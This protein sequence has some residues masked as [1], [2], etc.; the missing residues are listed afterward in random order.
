[1]LRHWAEE[2]FYCTHEMGL[3]QT[4]PVL[5][6]L[7]N[8]QSTN[9]F[10]HYPADAYYFGNQNWRAY[11]H[12]H[13]SPLNLDQEHGHLHIFT[14]NNIDEEWAHCFA[15]SMDKFGQPQYI[16]TTNLWVTEGAWLEVDQLIKSLHQLED[17]N[18]EDLLILDWLTSFI[19]TFQ[20]EI[21]DA[22]VKRDDT[23]SIYSRDDINEC[24]EDRNLYH[25]SIIPVSLQRKLNT[26]LV[27]KQVTA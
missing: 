5:L 11:Y 13:R 2:L 10:Q 4:N 17:D 20:D 15:L 26:L 3:Q 22:I 25:L 16:F 7:G 27:K 12:S 21:K 19:L 18:G 24:F 6:I 8:T 14:R 23:F 1:M 9:A